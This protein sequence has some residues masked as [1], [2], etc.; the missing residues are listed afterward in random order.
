[1]GSIY[2]LFI[3]PKA[4]QHIDTRKYYTV[5]LEKHQ[6]THVKKATYSTSENNHTMY[7]MSTKLLSYGIVLRKYFLNTFV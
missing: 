4:A 1:M 6:G 2:Y 5:K 7:L 3:T